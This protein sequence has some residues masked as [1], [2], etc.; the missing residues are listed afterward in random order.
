MKEYNLEVDTNKKPPKYFPFVEYV[1]PSVTLKACVGIIWMRLGVHVV[2]IVQATPDD[3]RKG[4][5]T[6]IYGIPKHAKLLM[7]DPTWIYGLKNLL[8]KE[9]LLQL[10]KVEEIFEDVHLECTRFGIVKSLNIIT[11]NKSGV[12]IY[13]MSNG[14]SKRLY[15]F[16]W[17]KVK[18]IP[19]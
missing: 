6:P 17:R 19:A 5:I 13:V 2:T 9:E 4:G 3:S 10:S 1:D 11:F 8:T 18:W 16:Y 14:K 7:Q 12:N 15:N